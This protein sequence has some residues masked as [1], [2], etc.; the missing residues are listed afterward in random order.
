MAATAHHSSTTHPDRCHHYCYPSHAL[1]GCILVAISNILSYQSFYS[2]IPSI[3][4][5]HFS[6]SLSYVTFFYIVNHILS[7]SLF[8]QS[9]LFMITTHI[10]VS[11]LFCIL[12]NYHIRF[13]FFIFLCNTLLIFHLVSDTNQVVITSVHRDSHFF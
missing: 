4:F 10:N 9:H 8:L 7:T 6:P 1:T 5:Y 11:F 12:A 13:Y 2:L 3:T